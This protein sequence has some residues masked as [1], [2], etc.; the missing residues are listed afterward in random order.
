MKRFAGEA[1][2]AARERLKAE[3]WTEENA[4]A[5]AWAEEYKSVS[6]FPLPWQTPKDSI[7]E[8]VHA[9]LEKQGAL[10]FSNR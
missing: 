7:W 10:K 6:V 9:I 5:K 3:E 1:I 2:E 8:K 4:D